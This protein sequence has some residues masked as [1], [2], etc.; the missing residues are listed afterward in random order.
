M[1]FLIS[2]FHK[3]ELKALL[4]LGLLELNSIDY[5]FKKKYNNYDNMDFSA[6][7]WNNKILIFHSRTNIYSSIFQALEDS[8]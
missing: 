6:I 3:S 2:S 1:Y 8:Q 4:S 7:F 5:T